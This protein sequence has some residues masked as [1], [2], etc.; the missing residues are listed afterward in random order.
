MQQFL[1]TRRVGILRATHAIAHFS[2]RPPTL[3]RRFWRVALEEKHPAGGEATA[4]QGA[5][6]L[7]LRR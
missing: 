6:G 4:I 2:A 7:A 1:I 3:V 5:K